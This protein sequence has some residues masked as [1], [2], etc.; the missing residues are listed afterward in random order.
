MTELPYASNRM[1]H[2]LPSREST[3]R[4]LLNL[5]PLLIPISLFAPMALHWSAFSVDWANHLFLVAT[6]ENSLR[7]LGHPSYFIHSTETGLYYPF[8]ALYGGSL[9]SLTALLA[10]VTGSAVFAYVAAYGIGFVTSYGGMFWIAR[11]TGLRSLLAHVPAV[12]TVTGAYYLTNAYA[13]GA[14]PEFMAVSAIPLMIAAFLDLCSSRQPRLRSM[15]ALYGAAVVFSGSHNITLLWGTIVLA[16]AGVVGAIALG[17]SALRASAGQLVLAGAVL[18]LACGTNFWFLLPDLVYSGQSVVARIPH[19]QY[20]EFDKAS[21]L[22]S[23]WH[24]TGIES[25]PTLFVQVSIYVL[26]WTL[27]ILTVAARARVGSRRTRT[28]AAGLVVVGA[29]LLVLTVF[30]SLWSYLPS[31]LLLIQFPYRLQSYVLLLTAGLSLLAVHAALRLPRRRLALTALAVAVACQV[32]LAEH[33]AWTAG[34]T[35]SG[36]TYAAY[37]GTGRAPPSWYSFV[38]Y[39][40]ASG[41]LVAPTAAFALPARLVRDDRIAVAMPTPPGDY[42]TNIVD[43][44]FVGASGAAVDAGYSPSVFLVVHRTGSE[45]RGALLTVAPKLPLAQRIGVAVSGACP[46]VMIALCVTTV[47]RVRRR[48]GGEARDGGPEPGQYAN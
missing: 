36:Q 19:V 2:R 22:F 28:F 14:W 43:S 39:R 18:V 25:A 32:G 16:L 38:E 15:L 45:P 20:L 41:S 34:H 1:R 44:P 24:V 42:E 37:A 11:L 17:P 4:L 47:W 31:T 9:Y 3:L 29:A 12:V 35:G 6:M 30:D 8:F 33:Q 40:I 5:L 21:V 46:L 27:A 23:P 26:A 13:R 48:S 10:I 7:E